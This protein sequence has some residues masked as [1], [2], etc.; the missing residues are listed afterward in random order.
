[1]GCGKSKT[2]GREPAAQDTAPG[3]QASA[4]SDGAAPGVS[5]Q[6][7]KS[8]DNGVATTPSRPS[9]SATGKGRPVT[10]SPD[11]HA[12]VDVSSPGQA[13]SLQSLYWEGASWSA[14]EMSADGERSCV[15]FR[16]NRN[17][18]MVGLKAG[19]SSPTDSYSDLDYAF[20]C[21]GHGWIQVYER[22]GLVHTASEKLSDDMVLKIRLVDSTVEYLIN[23][24][25]SYVSEA[26]PTEPLRLQVAWNTHPSAVIDLQY[27]DS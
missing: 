8:A 14:E 13:H 7:A 1:M 12:Q 27:T 18:I 5:A 19:T 4:A 15:C 25:V 10:F 22:G 11:G 16:V 6:P 20:Y 2:A 9:T 3:H 21:M 23:D 26:P 17:H 24:T